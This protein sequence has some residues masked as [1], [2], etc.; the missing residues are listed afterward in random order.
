MMRFSI[1]HIR[2]RQIDEAMRRWRESVLK[3]AMVVMAIVALPILAIAYISGVNQPEQWPAL[4]IF[5][6]NYVVMLAA[7]FVPRL[8]HRLRG[9][10]LLSVL[11]MIGVL[12]MARGGLAGVGREYLILL[13]I[14][15]FILV[16]VRSGLVATLLSLATLGVFTRLADAGQLEKWLIYQQNPQDLQAWLTEII[17]TAMI[18]IVVIV[19]LIFLQRFQLQNLEAKLQAMAELEEANARLEEYSQTLEERVEQRTA[20]LEKRVEELATLN[21]IMETVT[22]SL[23]ARAALQS[24]AKEMMRL[25]EAHSCGIALLSEDRTQLTLVADAHRDP[26]QPSGIGAAIPLEGNVSTL[27]VMESRRSLLVQEAE[28]SPLTV[29]I[30]ELLRS[31]H[32]HSLMILP[33]I[34]RGEVFGTIGVDR[35]ENSPPFTDENL[36]LAET[37]A[38]QVSGA[39]E[40]ARLFEEMQAARDVAEAANK[41]KSVFLAT[42]S[43]EI[44]TPMNAVIGMTSLLLNTNLTD[45]QREF[46]ETIRTSGDSLLTIINDIL[47]FSKIEAGKMELE[48]QPLL[49]RECIDGA[50]DL[51]APRVAEKN[52]EIGY[53][54]EG[55]VPAAI[56]GDVTRLRQ[57]LV[58]LIS[59]AV[60]FTD[61]G[62]VVINVCC[63][64]CGAG[65]S[66][67]WAEKAAACGLGETDWPKAGLPPD[68]HMLAKAGT[69]DLILHFSVQDTGIGI[70]VER[71]DRLFQS[72]SQ[73]D[74]SMTRRYGGTGLGLAVSKRLSELMGGTMWV[75]S[76]VG[77]GSIF[78]F[79]ILTQAAPT[80]IPAYLNL[81][82]PDLNGRRV[83]VVDDNATNRRI[84]MLQTH[85]W[86]MTSMITALPLQAL[87]WIR[88]GEEFDV[89]I[90]D[91][92]MPEMDGITLARE[93]QQLRKENPIP[94]V[95]LSSAVP[96]DA[97]MA[98]GIDQI[99][100]AVYLTK[101][102][103][104]SQLYNTL[105]E[106][107]TS[108]HV[109]QTRRE[110]APF[111]AE[112]GKRLPLRILLAEDN[113]TNQKLVLR[114]LE[115][116]GYRADVA[117]N[118]LE[119]LQAVQRQGY[120]VVLMDVQMP[121]M[122][123]LE[124]AR[125]ILEK[126]PVGGPRIIAMTANAMR[127][128][129]DVCLAA[130]MH[131]Y[132]S[133]PIR[134]DELVHALKRSRSLQAVAS[135]TSGKDDIESKSA[136]SPPSAE[137]TLQKIRGLAGEDQDFMLEIIDTYLEDAP[138]LLNR[139]REA[140]RSND[141]AELRL[142]AHSL[143][144]N[145]AEFGASTL[146]GLCRELEE[147]GKAALQ[148]GEEWKGWH[149][150]AIMEKLTAAE[151]AFERVRLA[152][153]QERAGM[154][155][156]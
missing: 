2:S 34:A 16:S 106:V 19:L 18:I 53:L 107:F 115:R 109:S 47:D 94:M 81:E 134:V 98:L 150:D 129:R 7:T 70:P 23:D 72:F 91:V 79:T 68:L 132:L 141:A 96:M 145:S 37:I 128:D 1:P 138:G 33:L 57:V 17:P 21:S 27:K 35:D 74:S 51:V 22:S 49:L 78:H 48:R 59:N 142:T 20:L 112:L 118:G 71:M 154:S 86:G 87:E 42:M 56:Y 133:K 77:Q 55:N 44:R 88:Q 130:G 113:V 8:E 6:L 43:H 117:G 58:N 32:V 149:V 76:A 152:L 100:F 102:V 11:Y 45:E 52:L 41:A 66:T 146:A 124:A 156:R 114:M 101:P 97:V 82:Q 9:W 123:G 26:K 83:L 93:I 5:T 148:G 67:T 95:M 116:L 4:V 73:V 125:Q 24:V 90:L 131:D 105:F 12:A 84:L 136:P 38:G 147:M 127:E 85:A 126:Q 137:V 75:E 3:I 29:M 144:S 92:Q 46:T 69:D 80:P 108:L 60:K 99:P 36:Q 62:E 13:P 135:D 25:F 143:K 122:D 151:D 65:S 120:D 39:I 15:A 153:E 54:L 140:A 63:L 50:L 31:R 155:K 30:H 10:I 103:K 28:T 14:L 121:E 110:E 104:A 61:E 40:N 89:A 139:M 111:D 119:A 64:K